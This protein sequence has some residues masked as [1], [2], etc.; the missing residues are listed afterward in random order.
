MDTG[1]PTRN[2]LKR[3]PESRADDEP[4]ECLWCGADST[5]LCDT[6]LRERDENGD[7]G[8]YKETCDAPLCE[9]CTCQRSTAFMSGP[10][11]HLTDT[12][13]AC[14]YCVARAGHR[15]GRRKSNTWRET[16][17]VSATLWRE[18]RDEH[19]RKRRT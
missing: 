18:R 6:L 7:L 8:F 19:A 15:R 5:R 2:L 12:I 16:D 4:I 1:A 3:D 11:G 10:G 9:A 13:D 17:Y 14:P